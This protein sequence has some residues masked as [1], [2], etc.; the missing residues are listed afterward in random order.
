MINKKIWREYIFHLEASIHLKIFIWLQGCYF[1][2][3]MTFLNKKLNFIPTFYI[4]EMKIGF[5]EYMIFNESR[6]KASSPECYR[7][8]RPTGKPKRY[9]N[10]NPGIFNKDP[11]V[12]IGEPK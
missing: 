5:Q 10:G 1:L 12:F 8:P 4:N 6:K 7:R 9:L 3:R 11:E 2:Q